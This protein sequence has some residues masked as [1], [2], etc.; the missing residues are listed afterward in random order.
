MTGMAS[1]VIAISCSKQYEAGSCLIGYRETQ[2]AGVRQA[3]TAFRC[4][5]V[6]D[7]GVEGGHLEICRLMRRDS[8]L[9]SAY[10]CTEYVEQHH[11]TVSASM[12][13][14]LVLRTKRW[15]LSLTLQ[16]IVTA[17]KFIAHLCTK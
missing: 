15:C 14:I 9:S 7:H 8:I 12:H 16:G 17:I 3:Q 5:T 2:D 13:R 6:Y 1:E 10:I 4:G 11:Y